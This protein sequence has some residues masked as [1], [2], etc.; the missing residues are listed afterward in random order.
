MLLSKP[1]GFDEEGVFAD[2]LKRL[3]QLPESALA[4]LRSYLN[5][6]LAGEESDDDVC[7]WL[8]RTTLRCRFHELRPSICREFELNSEECHSW[9]QQY[10]IDG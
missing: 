2:D 1:D 3:Q 7:L 6:L 9:R 10:R 8:D 5:K 4:E